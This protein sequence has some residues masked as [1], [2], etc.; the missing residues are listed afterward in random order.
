MRDIKDGTAL[1]TYRFAI[2]YLKTQL[3]SDEFKSMD[4]LVQRSAKTIMNA[5]EYSVS[6]GVLFI[7]I[8]MNKQMQLTRNNID[9]SEQV[10]YEYLQFFSKTAQG[11]QS[12]SI[13]TMALKIYWT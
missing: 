6:V 8:F 10:V 5:I 7:E 1:T 4:V 2:Q 9:E 13:Q 12:N 3:Q 11:F